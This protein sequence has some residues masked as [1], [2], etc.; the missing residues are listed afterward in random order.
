MCSAMNASEI[1]S[2][3]TGRMRESSLLV[4]ES[5][6]ALAVPPVTSMKNGES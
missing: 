6:I 2:F 4:P 1:P 5:L 3:V